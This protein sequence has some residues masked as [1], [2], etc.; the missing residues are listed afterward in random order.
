MPFAAV[1][2]Q[3]AISAVRANMGLFF[4]S[5]GSI[6]V[7]WMWHGIWLLAI[8][9][10]FYHDS[11]KEQV[12]CSQ[13]YDDDQISHSG[14]CDQQPNTVA[15]V[16]LCLC[17]YWTK[18]VIQNTVHTTTAGAV[19]SWWVQAAEEEYAVRNSGGCC[20]QDV[21]DS[22]H[23]ACTYSFGSICMGSL[24]VAVLQTLEGMA[25]NQRN[26]NNLVGL[27]LQC[28]IMCLRAYLEYF[29]SWA[30]CYVGK[31]MSFTGLRLPGSEETLTF[32][33]LSCL[34]AHDIITGIYGYSYLDA[35][36]KVIDLFKARGWTTFITDR[37][38]F[39][40]LLMANLGIA[41]LDG[42]LCILLAYFIEFS[43]VG[44]SDWAG[45]FAAAFW[46]GFFVGL[47]VSMPALFVL[48]SAVRTIIVCFAEQP[49][50]AEGGNPML[51]NLKETYAATYPDIFRFDQSEDVE[52]EVR[53]Q[54]NV[55]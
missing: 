53:E 15:I 29:N 42:A 4:L 41:A 16:L 43:K 10:V 24:L 14:M 55:V 5:G 44:T 46:F 25:R 1:N 2:L 6:I 3:T 48:E 21:S 22:L 52:L 8:A 28:I 19:G 11:Q 47:V 27:V 18:E 50:V 34:S 7:N 32:V 12:P 54:R 26:R 13:Y 49:I 23:R 38:I 33:L 40:V 20:G 31:F 17:Y 37:L 39:R 36:K 35:G 9:G 45:I 51:Q 30:F